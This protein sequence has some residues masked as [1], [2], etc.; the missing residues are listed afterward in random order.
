MA[1]DYDWDAVVQR[2]SV[3]AVLNDCGQQDLWARLAR[4]AVRDA[5][6]S[7]LTGFEPTA[8]GRVMNRSHREFGHSDYFYEG[9][10]RDAWIPFLKGEELPEPI[11]LQ[12]VRANRS[13]T[14]TI[15]LLLLAA[16]L[17]YLVLR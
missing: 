1:A 17:L 16:A 7:G 6:S 14:F 10:Y 12:P 11:R 15:T 13:F 4:R 8:A 2:G 9:N 3:I 5:G